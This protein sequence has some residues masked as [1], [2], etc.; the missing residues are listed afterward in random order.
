MSEQIKPDLAFLIIRENGVFKAVTDLS[1]EMD[2]SEAK[3]ASLFDMK[4]ACREILSAIDRND[5]LVGIRSLLDN[6][7]QKPAEPVATSIREALE[8]RDIL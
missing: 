7:V 8:E 1:T 2:T 4:I 5:I 6:Y 3:A